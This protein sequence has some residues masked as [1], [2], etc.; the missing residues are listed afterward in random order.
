M[1]R[2]ASDGPTSPRPL[3]TAAALSPAAVTIAGSAPDAPGTGSFV[4][5]TSCSCRRVASSGGR[6]ELPAPSVGGANVTGREC[7]LCVLLPFA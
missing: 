2:S 7:E 4:A 3:S 6:Q 1:A 5:D